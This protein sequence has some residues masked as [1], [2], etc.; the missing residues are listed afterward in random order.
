MRHGRVRRE[1]AGRP[2]QDL[3][4]DARIRGSACEHIL[5][6]LGAPRHD[7]FPHPRMLLSG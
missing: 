2:F 4:L 5:D 6:A 3:D 1:W 7:R